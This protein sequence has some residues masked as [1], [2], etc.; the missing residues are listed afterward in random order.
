MTSPKSDN[1]IVKAIVKAE[2][3]AQEKQ[4]QAKQE[5]ET[6]VHDA[7][8]KAQ[9]VIKQSLETDLKIAKTTGDKEAIE[10]VQAH[11]RLE[12][13]QLTPKAQVHLH[14]AIEEAVRLVIP[15]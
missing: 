2:K 14:A 11:A 4:Q 15:V 6:I 10:A 12:L 7:R 3:E 8:Q 1:D 9:S 13:K 5:A